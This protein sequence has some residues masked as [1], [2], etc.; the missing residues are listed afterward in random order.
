[1]HSLCQYLTSPLSIS[2]LVMQKYFCSYASLYYRKL[3]ET[4]A[5]YLVYISG[6]LCPTRFSFRGRKLGMSSVQA[7]NGNC[8]ACLSN[9]SLL[10][11]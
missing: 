6:T 3:L 7:R 5:R 4:S 11:Q 9:T 2:P 8:V 10:K 1:M